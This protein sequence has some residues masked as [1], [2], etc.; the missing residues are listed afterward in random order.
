MT[1][2]SLVYVEYYDHGS[3]VAW[4]ADAEIDLVTNLCI[5][6]AVGWVTRE[7]KKILC[8]TSFRDETGSGSHVRQYIIKACIIK[9]R[10]LKTPK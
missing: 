8:L 1:K 9:R 5:C 4:L 2:K 3:A 6:T 7:D 10:K